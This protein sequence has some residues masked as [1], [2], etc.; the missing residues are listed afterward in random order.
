[1]TGY[2]RSRRA[3]PRRLPITWRRGTES[4]HLRPGEELPCGRQ[5]CPQHDHHPGQL[6]DP[7]GV[8]FYK[9][10]VELFRGLSGRPRHEHHVFR[11]RHLTLRI[12]MPR[13]EPP[14]ARRVQQAHGRRFGADLP[15]RDR[16]HL[17]AAQHV[18]DVA[19]PDHGRALSS[20]GRHRPPRRSRLGLCPRCHPP[21]G[22][23]TP[24]DSGD[25]ASVSRDGRAPASKRI[26]FHCGGQGRP[27]RGRLFQRG[28]PMAGFLLPI[29]T[30]P[31][32]A[33]VSEPVK[34]VSTRS[35]CRVRCTSTSRNRRAAKW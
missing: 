12:P 13:F 6:P 24:E 25:R 31:L 3:R 5:H 19:L 15:R 30:I 10:S 33:C 14:L 18:A 7:E 20:A 21:R 2:Y 9:E 23:G 34:P 27:G 29:R 26:G 16:P 17:P 11:A 28:G 4:E 32:Q 1:M 22:R 8:A 35:S